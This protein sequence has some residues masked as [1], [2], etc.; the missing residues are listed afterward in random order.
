M[1]NF[2]CTLKENCTRSN[3]T[4]GWFNISHAPD[5]DLKI[6]LRF[7]ARNQVC[8]PSFMHVCLLYLNT[9][10]VVTY[11]GFPSLVLTFHTLIPLTSTIGKCIGKLCKL[12]M[13]I[14]Q[15]FSSSPI[16]HILKQYFMM[17]TQKFAMLTTFPLYHCISYFHIFS[18]YV[19]SSLCKF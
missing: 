18:D 9:C 2:R 6:L 17:L 14:R 8:A 16:K 19:L 3:S 12:N 1:Y 7:P 15:M 4:K 10:R 5:K 13:Q 11:C